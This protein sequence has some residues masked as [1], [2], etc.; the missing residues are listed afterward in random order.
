MLSREPRAAIASAEVSARRQALR[1][2]RFRVAERSEVVVLIT[3][4][5]VF[6]FFAISAHNFLTPFALSNILTFASINGILVLGVAMLMISGEFD[7]SV[8]ST[9]AV[10][11]YVFALSLIDGVNPL[12]AMGL[13]LLASGLLGLTNGWIVVQTGIPSFITTLG[14]ML[15]FRGIARAIGGGVFA[16]YTGPKLALLGVLNGPIEAVNRLSQPPANFRVSILWFVILAILMSYLLL[17]TRYGN[18]TYATGGNPGAA[19][20]QGVPIGRVRLVNF[21]LAGLLAG[22]AGVIQFAHRTSVDPLRGFGMELIA[23]A[24]CVIGGVRL[25]GGSGTIL[26]PC[27]GV[28]LLQMLEQGLVLLRVPVQIFQAVAGSFLI[29]AVIVNTWL[30]G[31]PEE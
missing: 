8:G 13:A 12:L 1:E 20:A 26:G 31:A 10:A 30:G 29:L 23:V 21:G 18:W 4:I 19:K 9:F 11:S 24:A 3:I 27:I 7:L 22:A 14:T 17:R 6:G 5:L 15:A 16:S 28:L 25:N 2:L